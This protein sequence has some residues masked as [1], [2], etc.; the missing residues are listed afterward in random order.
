VLTGSPHGTVKAVKQELARRNV[1]L[2]LGKM[3]GS[4]Q[5]GQITFADGSCLPADLVLWAG[6]ATAPPLLKALGLPTD[7]NGF[8]LTR[9]SLQSVGHDRIFAVGDTGTSDTWPTPKAGVY[10]VRQGP[11]LWENLQRLLRREPLVDYVPQRGFLS[12]LNLGDGRAILSY[13]GHTFRG[14]W[15]W[16]LKDRIDSRFMDMYQDYT[17]MSMAAAPQTHDGQPPA[18]R[19]AGCG[20]KVGGSVLSQ[21]LQRLDIPPSE[22]VLLGLEQPDDAAIIRAPGGRPVVCTVD[23]FAAFLD[24][25]YLVGRVAALNA[26]SDLFAMGAKPLAALALA[27]IPVGPPRQQEQLLYELLAGGLQE[28]RRM[29]ATLIGGHTIEGPQVTIGYAMLADAGPAPPRTKGGLRPADLLVLTKPLGTG[30]LLAAHGQA[31]CKA[32]WM[33][34]LLRQL[35]VSNQAA[36]DAALEFNLA[37]LTDVTGFGLAGH[38]LEMLRPS[39]AAAE[40]WLDALP[41]LPGVGELVQQGVQ[42]T[43]APANRAAEAEIE[44]QFAVQTSWQYAVLFD[45]QTSGGMLLGVPEGE[46]EQVL[47]RLE[48][49]GEIPP[50]VIG[51]VS[52]HQEGDRRLRVI[53]AAAHARASPQGERAGHPQREP[54]R[55]HV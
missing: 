43:L 52:P 27:T 25:P 2:V 8:L 26:A 6:S 47:R 48:S 29:G 23:F 20:G 39:G 28:F 45:P 21:V 24:D 19:C 50:V 41:L 49:A 30:I 55:P 54:M 7:A 34:V 18:M 22:H 14:A 1:Q 38:L 5:S 12:L 36:A 16:R 31:R 51:R 42:S 13:K 32:P 10:A 33:D 4:V 3:V 15:C 37:G 53:A 17:P 11:I 35:L 40:I 46:L 44:A 9:P